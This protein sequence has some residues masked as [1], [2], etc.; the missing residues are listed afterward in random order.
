MN[1]SPNPYRPVASVD[2]FSTCPQSRGA[3]PATYVR[4]VQE[5]ARWSEEI[6]CRGILVYA[7]NG[8]VDPWLTADVICAQTTTLSPLVAVQPIYMH[9]YSVAKMIASFAFMHGRRLHLNMVA[10]GFRNDL[11]ALDDP[12]PHDERYDRVVEYTTIVNAL[13]AGE[14]PVTFEGKYYTVHGLELAPP[15]PHDLRPGL[16]MSGSSPAGAA[17]AAA[18]GATPVRYP[19]PPGEDTDVLEPGGGLRIGI[20]ARE[21]PAEA[22]DLA[23]SRFP[24]DRRGQLTHKVAM[25]VSDSHWHRQLGSA[26]ASGQ[27]GDDGTPFPYWLGPFHNYKTFCPYLV[28]SYEDVADLLTGYLRAGIGTFVLDIPPSR[29]ELEHTAV[30]FDRAMDGVRG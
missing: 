6:G 22:W 23:L 24:E 13:V 18:I 7:D 29:E 26:E 14:T 15:V 25:S 20:V 2:L 3:D 1:S 30:V 27:A 21:D 4:S 19:G 12:T 17:A 9:P 11:V 10:G 8:L 5:A 28:G 16:L